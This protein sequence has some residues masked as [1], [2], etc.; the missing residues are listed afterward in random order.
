MTAFSFPVT[1]LSPLAM[2]IISYFFIL[3]ID[4]FDTLDTFDPFDHLD[5][6]DR[7]DTLDILAQLDTLDILDILGFVYASK[8]P[9]SG[10]NHQQIR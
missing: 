6:L 7:L 1:R 3:T 10:K 9:G 5:Q 4:T 2:P 8:G